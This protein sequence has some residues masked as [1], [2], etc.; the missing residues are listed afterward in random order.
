MFLKGLPQ[1]VFKPFAKGYYGIFD[2]LGMVTL[3][4]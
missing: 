3:W 1:A 2:Y 4:T